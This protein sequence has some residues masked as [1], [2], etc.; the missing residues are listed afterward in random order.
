MDRSRVCAH[1]NHGR[2][3]I[4]RRLIGLKFNQQRLGAD[5]RFGL[6]RLRE[7]AEQVALMGGEAAERGLL[8][9]A[10]SRALSET[11]TPSC[12]GKRR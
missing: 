3:L 10:A 2:S 6:V 5:F 8:S 7:N 12:A 1:G 9:P 11:G 4:G